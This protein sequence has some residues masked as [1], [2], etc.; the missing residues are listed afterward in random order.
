VNTQLIDVDHIGRSGVI[1]VYLIE[2]RSGYALVDCGPQ[3]STQSLLERLEELGVRLEDIGDLLLTHIHFDHAGGAGALVQK[4]PGLRVHV[5]EIGAPHLA[6]PSRLERSARRIYGDEFD[7]LWG[8]VL[9]VSESNLAVV[10]D[11]AAGLE[12]FPTPGHASHHVSYLDDEGVLFAGDVAGIRIPGCEYVVP[13]TPPPDIDVRRWHDS[14]RRIE[15]RDVQRL[16]ITHFGFADDVQQH[17]AEL[18]ARLDSWWERVRSGESEDD[19]VERAGAELAA[20][21]P[22]ELRGRYLH[23]VSLASCYAGLARYASVLRDE[24]AA[25]RR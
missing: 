9:P 16:A 5:S 4:H 24:A 19:F 20:A 23:S 15:E 1:A 14:L 25:E 6:D 10:T 11:E 8:A 12:C 17:L 18:G 7:R 21:V 2:T 22:G 3:S 13:P